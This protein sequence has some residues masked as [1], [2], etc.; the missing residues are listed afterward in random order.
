MTNEV[1]MWIILFGLALTL[2]WFVY[3][4]NHPEK[5]ETQLFVDFCTKFFDVY[6]DFY[7]LK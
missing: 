7:R 4:Y 3:R 1:K 2:P 5:S 6:A